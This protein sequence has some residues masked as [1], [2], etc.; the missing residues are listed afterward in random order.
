M[1]E[2]RDLPVT[3]DLHGALAQ[4]VVA[5][6][7]GEAGWQ[8]VADAG[9][10]RPVLALADRPLAGRP[11]VVVVDGRPDADQTRA[12]LLAGALD[13]VGW[14][15]DRARLLEVPLRVLA[16]RPAGGTTAVLRV[17]GAAGGVGT[18]TVALALAGLLAWSGRRTAV[19][20]DDDLLRLCGLG[21]WRGPGV[22]EV[23]ALHA[24]DARREVVELARPVAGVPG[25]CAL[26]G[27]GA[28]W[29]VDQAGPAGAGSWPMDAVVVDLRDRPIGADLVVARPDAGLRSIAGTHTPVVLVGEGPLDARGVRRVIGRPPLLWLPASARVARA[30]LAGR[31]PSALPGRWLAAVRAAMPQGPVQP[32]VHTR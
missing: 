29:T 8:V 18:S 2:L 12:A 24:T 17:G 6:V 25:L 19:A 13:V 31:V 11:C 22:A 5:Y 7:E 1:H 16:A 32:V 27:A 21:P 9:P 4:E 10:P 3:V 26:G 20:G 28:G 30:G 15:D 14:P 23:A